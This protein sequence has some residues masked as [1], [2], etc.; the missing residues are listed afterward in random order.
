MVSEEV[1]DLYVVFI[2]GV[3]C[4][5]FCDSPAFEEYVDSV[6]RKACSKFEVNGLDLAQIMMVYRDPLLN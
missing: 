3:F 6:A 2:P 5:P 1:S 4:Y